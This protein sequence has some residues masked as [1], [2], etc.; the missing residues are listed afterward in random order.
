M[1]ALLL[2]AALAQDYS[3][4]TTA[5]DG[6]HFYPTA[7]FDHG[8]SDWNCG[9]DTYSGHRGSDFGVGG[10]SGMDAGRAVVAADPGTVVATND[11]EFDRC[12]TAN[13]SGGGGFGNYV[14]IDHADG[15]R[16]IYAHLKQFSLGVSTG[17]VVTCGQVLGEV[18]SSGF[19]TG[20]HLHFEV[21]NTSGTSADP[22]DGNCSFPPS[23][24]VGQ[25]SYQGLPDITCAPATCEP[26]DTLSCGD[27]LSTAN[28]GADSTDQSLSYGCTTFTYSGPERAWTF[29]APHDLPVTL[30]MSG[31]SADL[32]LF[33]M[34]GDSC[35]AN[36]CIEG[37]T[38]PN[39]SDEDVVFT[40][41]A[42][43]TY[44]VVVEGWDDAVSSFSLDVACDT[45]AFSLTA[46]ALSP[47][48]P[49]T[50]DITGAPPNARV[51]IGTSP[52][53]PGTGPCPPVLGG[54]CLALTQP[55]LLGSLTVDGAGSGSLTA[56]APIRLPSGPY[57]F[58]AA[59]ADGSNSLITAPVQVQVP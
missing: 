1:I 13:C 3:F 29:T 44:T 38:N 2:T 46:S 39:T 59:V 31:L 43:Q 49:A 33:V 41:V 50:F 55:I 34:D 51:M 10:F 54:Q 6:V 21:R 8:G 4:P 16:T 22:F 14:M 17:D 24:W 37:S 5:A 20:P 9:N 45:P 19:S 32:D 42:G 26:V 48:A 47:G 25:G 11:G 35:D 15:K 7:Y 23:W 12:T 57:T 18:G 27:S 28:N 56:T 30:S 40:P 58:Q 52:G 53:T 36:S